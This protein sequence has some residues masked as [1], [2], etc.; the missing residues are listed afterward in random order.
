MSASAIAM[1]IISIAILWGGLVLSILR[2]RK[3]PE[4]PE[5]DS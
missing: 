2:L 5:D 3:H 1:L 4:Q